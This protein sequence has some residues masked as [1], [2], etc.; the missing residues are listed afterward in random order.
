MR[1]VR[2]LLL[3]IAA[4]LV[5]PIFGRE[6]IFSTAA[7]AQDRHADAGLEA[8]LP[9]SLAGSA[10]VRESQRGSELAR[11]S[12][13][14]D[15]MLADLDRTPD[16]FVV[17]SA[18]ASGGLAAEVG[19]WRVAGIDAERLLPALVA[20][21]R[22]SST[23][24][25]DVTTVEVAGRSVTRVGAPGQLTRGPLY[26]LPSRDVLLFVQTPDPGLAATAVASFR[27]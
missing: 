14:F 25:V 2:A 1:I 21:V 11:R 17:A 13:A 19:A 5:S 7:T 23:T 24:P 9:S 12:P 16:D 20:A 22:Q 26:V 8:L 6:A 3:V 10:L 15:R 4:A 18:S 27:S